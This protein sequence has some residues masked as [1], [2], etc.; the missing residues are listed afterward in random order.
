MVWMKNCKKYLKEIKP[1]LSSVQMTIRYE[2]DL[3][4]VETGNSNPSMPSEE[5]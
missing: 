2:Y 3:G 5:V 4:C 1:I